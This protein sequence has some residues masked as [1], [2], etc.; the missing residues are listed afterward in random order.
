[1]VFR[2]VLEIDETNHKEVLNQDCAVL[3][4]FNDFEMDCLM[5]LPVINALA[6]EFSSIMFGRVNIDDF[7]EFAER[8]EVEKVPCTIILRRGEI[9]EKITGQIDEDFLRQRLGEYVF[10]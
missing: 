2:E 7:E 1:M 5:C 9:V 10:S 6:E 3:N 8:H 4:F